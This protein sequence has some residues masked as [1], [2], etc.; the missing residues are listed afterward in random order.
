MPNITDVITWFQVNGISLLITLIIFF[1]AYKITAMVAARAMKVS[2]RALGDAGRAKAEFFF[3]SAILRLIRLGF[4]ILFALYIAPF[5]GINIAPLLAGIGIGGIALGFASQLLVR[6]V[7]SGIVLLGENR[8]K[9]GD[10]IKVGET[11]G[12]IEDFDLR[13]IYVKGEN[14]ENHYIPFGEI[15][16]LTKY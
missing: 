1:I 8:F 11:I 9:K 3:S 13:G 14:A 6:D 12:I 2:L 15:R 16:I 10:K 5:F 7:I 4:A